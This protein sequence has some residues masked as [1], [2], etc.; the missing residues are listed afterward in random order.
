MAQSGYGPIGNRPIGISPERDI[1]R[2]G[3]DPIEPL[4]NCIYIYLLLVIYILLELKRNRNYLVQD[5][6]PFRI[7]RW[8]DQEATEWATS[9]RAIFR[10][11][12]GPFVLYI[13]ILLKKTLSTILNDR[14][15]G[16]FPDREMVQLDRLH[17]QVGRR[18]SGAFPKENS[19]KRVLK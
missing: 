8:P 3:S 14:E 5:I 13:Y 7:G 9:D 4:T 1:A 10:S 11:G 17:L 12:N 19:K 2:S 6:W 16:P 18:K 15:L